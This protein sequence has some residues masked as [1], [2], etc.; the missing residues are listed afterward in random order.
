MAHKAFGY[1]IYAGADIDLGDLKYMAEANEIL[2]RFADIFVDGKVIGGLSVS[3]KN[4]SAQAKRLGEHVLL[5]VAD[6]STYRP[7]RT[8]VTVG[9]PQYLADNFTD[10]ETGEH[11]VYEGKGL[12]LKV[13]LSSG[14][15]ARVFYG[16]PGW[17]LL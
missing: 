12:N 11:L 6:Y 1:N 7:I 13:M 2:P 16:G 8:E 4:I 10:V 5:L 9:L 3:K 17:K 15:R 14:R